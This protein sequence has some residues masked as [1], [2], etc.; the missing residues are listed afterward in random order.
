ME[1]PGRVSRPHAGQLSPL[2]VVGPDLA[3][4]ELVAWLAQRQHGVIV[5][6][7]LLAAGLSR[8]VIYGACNR[9]RPIALH[10]GVFAVGHRT[11]RVESAWMA[12]VLACGRLAV[13]SHLP[14]TALTGL[15][16]RNS[17]ALPIDISVASRNY[18]RRPSI[19][20]H[21]PAEL[22]L[23][24]VI[25]RS[26]IPCTSIARTV[27]DCASL[28]SIGQLEHL[29]EAAEDQGARHL[30]AIRTALAEKPNLSGSAKLRQ[31]LA[32]RDPINKPT[33]SELERRMFRLCR[34]RWPAR[35]RGQR[36][37]RD[38]RRAPAGRLC[39]G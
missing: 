22:R 27:I 34:H 12:A 3:G 25:K 35:A 39:L 11:D 1:E 2:T 33:K 30:E 14:A 8:E 6:D 24:E 20:V 18:R 17:M 16:H 21:R 28:L 23:D 13:L 36:V 19:R 26:L 38:I 10:R 4:W 32:D 9:G 5:T 37:D 29:L 31:L 15:S 7:Q